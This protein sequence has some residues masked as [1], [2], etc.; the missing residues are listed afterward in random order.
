MR[1]APACLVECIPGGPGVLHSRQSALDCETPVRCR[2]R[3]PPAIHV[4][5]LL[6]PARG[7]RVNHLNSYRLPSP[8]THACNH[9]PGSRSESLGCHSPSHSQNRSTNVDSLAPPRVLPLGHSSQSVAVVECASPVLPRDT[10]DTRAYGW[11]GSPLELT[12]PPKTVPAYNVSL[13]GEGAPE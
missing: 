8:D 5:A 2:A 4:A 3:S 9:P 12:Q 6:G 7:T 1:S 10:A 11:L 13:Q